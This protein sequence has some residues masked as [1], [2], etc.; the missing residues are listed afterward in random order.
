MSEVAVVGGGPVG[1]C[2]ATLLARAGVAVTLLEPQL[3]QPPAPGSP[4]D[5]RVVALSRASEKLLQGRRRLGAAS[6]GERLAS[7]ERMRIWHESVAPESAA[8]LVFDAADVGEPNLGYILENRLLQAALLRGLQRRRRA[9][10]AR[11]ARGAHA[12]RRRRHARTDSRRGAGA[13]RDRGRRGALGG[14]RGRRPR[15]RHPRL[16]PARPSSPRSAPRSP[17]GTPPG[18]ASCTTARSPSC[19][20]PTAPARSCGRRMRRARRRCSA[21]RARPAF[22]AALDAGLGPRA[23]RDA[24]RECAQSRLPCDTSRPRAT[25]PSASR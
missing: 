4:L 7:Y 24:P 5:A 15:R 17:T 20:W 25:S 2:A 13:A 3:P 12:E 22:A 23:R 9:A 1:A 10:A 14:A 16:P 11:R 8:A 19:R 18:S 21:L 6:P